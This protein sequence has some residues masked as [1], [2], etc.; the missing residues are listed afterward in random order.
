MTSLIFPEFAAALK[1]SGGKV[2]GANGT[3]EADGV[4]EKK[5]FELRNTR[6]TRK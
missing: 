2:F 5:E 6:N 4:A 1:Q 3:A